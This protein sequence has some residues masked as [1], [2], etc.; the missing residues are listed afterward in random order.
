LNAQKKQKSKNLTNYRVPNLLIFYMTKGDKSGK[1]VIIGTVP[2]HWYDCG[3]QTK[4]I[5]IS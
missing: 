1:G 5:I 3:V 4:Q 2:E